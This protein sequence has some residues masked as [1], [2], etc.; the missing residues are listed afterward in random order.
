MTILVDNGDNAQ[1]SPANRPTTQTDAYNLSGIRDAF[2]MTFSLMCHYWLYPGLLPCRAHLRRAAIRLQSQ[3][4][5]QAC[6]RPH[7]FP[8]PPRDS[9]LVLTPIAGKA[10]SYKFTVSSA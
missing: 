5:P 2:I 9:L 6:G 4:V 10:R 1:F 8:A 7:E 3:T